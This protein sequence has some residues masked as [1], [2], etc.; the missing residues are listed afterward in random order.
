[1][2]RRRQKWPLLH[3]QC[4]I[5][6]NHWPVGR[7]Q[8]GLFISCR[9]TISSQSWWAA[10]HRR[11]TKKKE[12][13]KECLFNISR[14]LVISTVKSPTKETGSVLPVRPKK[15]G[16]NNWTDSPSSV[17]RLLHTI[18]MCDCGIAAT[19]CLITRSCCLSAVAAATTVFSFYP[20]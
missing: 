12:R 13:K 7:R 10:K 14:S 6:N 5:G 15:M 19:K 11:D 2:Q 18:S 3:Q 1:M 20:I 9:G 8:T 16:E 4:N 17:T